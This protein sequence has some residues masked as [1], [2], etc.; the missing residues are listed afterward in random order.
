MAKNKKRQ[1]ILEGPAFT[2]GASTIKGGVR[3]TTS[4]LKVPKLQFSSSK[5]KDAVKNLQELAKKQK[6]AHKKK[7]KRAKS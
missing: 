5:S 1:E 4:E 7:A 3:Q 6:S 2:G